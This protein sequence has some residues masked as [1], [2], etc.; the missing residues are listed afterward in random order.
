MLVPAPCTVRWARPVDPEDAPG[1][2]ALLDEHERSRLRR[3]RR[4][5]DRAR[6]LA[7]HALVRLALGELLDVDGAGIEI[8]R[9][10][11][12][13]EQHGKPVVRGGGPGFSLTHSGDLVG[14]A[15]R[16]DGPVGLDA[17]GVRALADL[18]AMARH[19]RSPAEAVRGD[20]VTPA[21]FFISWTRK[22]ALLK[23]TGDGLSVP[24]SAITLDGPGLVAW[25]GPRATAE[26]MWLLD[27]HPAPGHAAAL[28]GP[29]AAA[30]EVAELRGDELLRAAARR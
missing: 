10:C 26:P 16:H 1:L 2:V 20:P 23:A 8:D 11:R 21:T 4:D 22:E 30:P 6:Y 17:E 25:T 18:P 13:G 19:T 7:A 24:M 28:A 15:I 3:F 12:C 14:V 27:L 5:A 9:T 29:G